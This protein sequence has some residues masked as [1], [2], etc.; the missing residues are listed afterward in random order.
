MLTGTNGYSG[1]TTILGGGVTLRDGGT[2]LASNTSAISVNYGTLMIDQTGLNPVGSL[3]PTRINPAVPITLASERHALPQRRASVDSSLTVNTLTTAT[4]ENFIE[5]KTPY[6]NPNTQGGTSV[7]NI[8]SLVQGSVQ[9]TVRFIPPQSLN[10]FGEPGLV[11]SKSS[12]T[13]SRPSA[14]PPRPSPARWST[15]SCPAG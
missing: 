10:G 5:P 4:G 1:T 3:N 11:L 14:A 12:S 9:G 2:L 8:G 6:A 15:A 7:I 13:A